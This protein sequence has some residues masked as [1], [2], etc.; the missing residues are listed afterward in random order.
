MPSVTAGMPLRSGAAVLPWLKK[1]MPT[2]P[3]AAAF[4]PLISN[5]QVPRWISAMLPA[6][7]P[8]KSAAS[9]PLVDALPS[10]SARST[11]GHGRRDLT[12]LGLGRGTEVGALDVGDRVGR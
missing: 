8:V 9:H 6:G 2:A 1:R 5:V 10:P 4:S 3:A 12:R 7:K 11:A